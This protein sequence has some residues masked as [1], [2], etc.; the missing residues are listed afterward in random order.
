MFNELPKPEAPPMPLMSL[1][2]H[3]SWT[4]SQGHHHP[5]PSRIPS[6]SEESINNGG[7]DQTEGLH[8]IQ[9]ANYYP[10]QDVDLRFE[11]LLLVDISKLT[12]ANSLRS[13]SAVCSS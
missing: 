8:P 2:G 13:H 5:L 3:E 10:A 7:S 11:T 9:L 12:T 4:G 6:W 1:M